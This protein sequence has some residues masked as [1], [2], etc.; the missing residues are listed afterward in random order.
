MKPEESMWISYRLLLYSNQGHLRYGQLIAF[1][2]NLQYSV[3]KELNYRGNQENNHWEINNKKI[4]KETNCINVNGNIFTAGNKVYIRYGRG[5]S[6]HLRQV[7]KVFENGYAL[8]ASDVYGNDVPI[9]FDP[10]SSG[11]PV[12]FH[13][14][15]LQ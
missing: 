2:D 13:Y 1:T 11:M 6:A 8:T 12:S 3:V 14:K 10:N 5:R 7:L 4:S 15:K 9:G